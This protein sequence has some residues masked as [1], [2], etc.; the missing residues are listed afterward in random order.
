M[1]ALL[2]VSAITLAACSTEPTAMPTATLEPAVALPTAAPTAAPAAGDP[3]QP[4]GGMDV[5]WANIIQ[6]EGDMVAIVNGVPIGKEVYLEELRQ[7]LQSVTQ[8]YSLDWNDE[9]TVSYLPTF[10]DEIL[11]QMINEELAAQL[12]IAEGIVID[13]AARDAELAKV[14]QDMVAGGQFETWEAFLEAYGSTQE[15]IRDD[16]TSYLLYQALL[17]AHGGP[18]EAEQVHAA[19]ILVETEEIGQEVLDKLAEGE[20]FA[21]LAVE[22]ST[23]PGSGPQGGDLGWFPPG[24][25]VPEFEE[26]AFALDV[27]AIS[28]LVQSD[29]GYHII[30]VLDKGI[31]PLDPSLL[32]QRQQQSFQAWFQAELEAAAVQTLVTFAPPT[33]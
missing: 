15:S 10:Q 28:G 30:Q 5:A 13:D 23:D 9:E 1:L 6:P 17:E 22:Y 33:T 24:M 19:H 4:V 20:S 7:Q 12:A 32:E 31:H 21:D 3:E 18:T 16:T 27:S 29:F 8:N 2:L 11:A 25:M 26:A 14:E